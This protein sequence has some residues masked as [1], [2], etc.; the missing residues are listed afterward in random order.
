MSPSSTYAIDR[1]GFSMTGYKAVCHAVLAAARIDAHPAHC[2]QATGASRRSV[3]GAV[4]LPNRQD[5]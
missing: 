1:Y 5:K 4:W 3:L 2:T